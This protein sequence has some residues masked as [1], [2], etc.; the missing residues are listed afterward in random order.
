VLPVFGLV[1]MAL[2]LIMAA[3]MVSLVNTGGI[4]T[5]RLPS[6]VPLW[7]GALILLIAYQIIVSPVRAVQQWSWHSSAAAQP[8][9]FAFWNAVVW[10]IGLA[11]VLWIASN[12]VPE[13]HAFVRKTPELIR[14]FTQALRDL[15]RE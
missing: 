1:H 13:I 5:W 3:M 12:H 10:L 6:D 15:I 8:A 2:F 7:A 14:D 9:L 4:L 11:F